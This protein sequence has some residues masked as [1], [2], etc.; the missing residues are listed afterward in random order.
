MI[1]MRNERGKVN[2]SDSSPIPLTCNAP[3]IIPTYSNNE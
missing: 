2:M 1:I 3:K